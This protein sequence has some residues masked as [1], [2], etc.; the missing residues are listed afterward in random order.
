MTT[1]QPETVLEPK[2]SSDDA[3]A[4]PWAG[5]VHALEQAEIYWIS[6]VRPDGRPHVTPMIGLW[7]DDALYFTTGETERKAKNL[8]RNPRCA[9]TTGCNVLN[10]GLDVVIEGDAVRASVESKLQQLAGLYKSKYDWNFSVREGAFWL[11]GSEAPALVFAVAPKTV[12]GFGKGEPFSQ[13]RW[14]F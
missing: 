8:E 12:F 2:F 3:T 14:R 11:E 4:T 6:T 13:T 5:A 1:N 7:L 9:I 10:E